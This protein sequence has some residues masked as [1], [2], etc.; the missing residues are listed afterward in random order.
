MI[1]QKIIVL[2]EDL[3][4]YPVTFISTKNNTN[5]RNKKNKRNNRNKTDQ[6]D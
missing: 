3:T 4:P 6:I 5:L 2:N 1:N